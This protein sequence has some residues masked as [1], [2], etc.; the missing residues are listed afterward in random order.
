MYPALFRLTVVKGV[1]SSR[2]LLQ[3]KNAA[4]L[5]VIAMSI[6][7]GVLCLSISIRRMVTH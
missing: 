5:G 7:Y 1:R 4:E 3:H 6:V 2:D